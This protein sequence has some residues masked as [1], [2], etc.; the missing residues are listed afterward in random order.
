V[1]DDGGLVVKSMYD[2]R[3]EYAELMRKYDENTVDLSHW[4]PWFKGRCRPILPGELVVIMADTGVGKT[5]IVGNIAKALA[6]MTILQFHLELPGSLVFERAAARGNKMS[7]WE[8]ENHFRAGHQLVSMAGIDHVYVVD[9]SRLTAEQMQT[10]ILS[11]HTSHKLG[12]TPTVAMVDYIGL[13]Q[14]SSGRSRY[15]KVSAAAEDLKVMAK[16]T[17]TVVIVATQIHRKPEDEGGQVGLHDAKDSGS[18]E[19]SAD[20]L[21]GAWREADTKEI[22]NLRILKNRKGPAGEQ[23]QARFNL[24]TMTISPIVPDAMIGV[25][26]EQ[27]DAAERYAMQQEP[28]SADPCKGCHTIGCSECE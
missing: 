25:S 14:S 8:I 12:E 17:N 19:A 27:D 23:T 24:E 20:L 9:K 6:P 10:A 7:A 22:I 21:I 11:L 16:E 4:L 18:I 26:T 13:M 15:E 3:D 2:L 5:A 28:T 1:S